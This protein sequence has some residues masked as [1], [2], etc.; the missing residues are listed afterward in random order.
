[1]GLSAA[2]RA[3]DELLNR[4]GDDAQQIRDK[5]DRMQL[6]RYRHGKGKPSA[7]TAA[8]LEELSGG[9]VPANGWVDSEESGSAA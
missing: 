1:M 7:E 9:T 2:S 5:V 4:G 8:K 6:W 3:L